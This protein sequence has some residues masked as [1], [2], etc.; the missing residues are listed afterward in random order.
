MTIVERS[1]IASAI[2]SFSIIDLSTIAR[3]DASLP[4]GKDAAA[5]RARCVESVT[6]HVAALLKDEPMAS[7]AVVRN[8]TMAAPGGAVELHVRLTWPDLPVAGAGWF[9]V[10]ARLSQRAQPNATP[11]GWTEPRQII[12][13]APPHLRVLRAGRLVDGTVDFTWMNRGADV[14]HQRWLAVFEECFK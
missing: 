5:W 13:R 12:A 14:A 9:D 8:Q 7:A 3:A 6:R 2:I 11:G 10:E 1:I 4:S